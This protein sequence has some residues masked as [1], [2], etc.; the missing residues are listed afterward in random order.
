MRRVVLPPGTLRQGKLELP[1]ELAHYV[2]RVLRAA[3]G[4]GLLL[5]DGA[6][7]SGEALI[8]RIDPLV[9]RVGAIASEPRTGI[10]LTLI[11]AVGKR[12]KM[13]S[14]VRQTA[15]LGVARIV[16]VLTAR[17]VAKQQ[18]RIGRWQTIADDALRVA[19]GLYR[20]EVEPVVPL[21]DVLERP[22][23]ECALV[24]AL[25]SGRALRRQ[26]EQ[27]G[28]PAEAELMIG[29]EGGLTEQE[30][31]DAEAAGFVRVDLG[32]RTLRTE[33]AGPAAAAILLS[34]AGALGA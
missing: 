24:L 27:T 33:T 10:Q 3:P 21:H 8:E 32:P 5:M 14:V 23:T 30:L 26:L 1:E 17:T 25:G 11:Q 13:D 4:D 29:P 6:G 34:H 19:G 28:V 18:A 15:E 31:L 12:D 20:T 7:A 9:L 2:V 22:R 16:P